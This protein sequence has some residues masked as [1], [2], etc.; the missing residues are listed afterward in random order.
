MRNSLLR[1][2]HRD[3][4]SHRLHPCQRLSANFLRAVTFL[5][6]PKR[7]WKAVTYYGLR[8]KATVNMS[9]FS[10]HFL[11]SFFALQNWFEFQ[12]QRYNSE[13]GLPDYF[14]PKTMK[15]GFPV[16]TQKKFRTHRFF[17]NKRC[18]SYAD[19]EE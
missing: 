16:I 7:I 17:R 6:T 9:F 14:E 18:C 3:T 15:S 5:L 4:A 11:N 19:W 8:L 12:I 10:V 2:S 13:F 1:N